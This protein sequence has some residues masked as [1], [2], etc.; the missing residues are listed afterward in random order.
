MRLYLVQHG[1]AKSKQE[2][3]DR[4]LTGEGV[5]D[6]QKV[7]EFIKPLGLHVQ[8]IWH[9]GKA[10]AEQ[11]A[12]LLSGAVE[13]EEGALRHDGLAPNDSVEF[14]VGKM[15]HAE[16]DLMIVGHLPFLSK[17]AATLLVGNDASEVVAFRN[18][19]VVCLEGE[20]GGAWRLAWM[21]TPEL[22]A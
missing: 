13:A 21:V 5:Q 14:L 11:T 19:G 18:G 17:L 3:P 15:N 9:S 22:L 10:R 6:V 12:E 8:T 4:H 2:D 16:K 7:A 20:S 1:K